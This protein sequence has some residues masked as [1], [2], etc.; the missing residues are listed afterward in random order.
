MGAD[1]I[2]EK[3]CAKISPGRLIGCTVEAPDLRAGAAL[4]VAGLAA[5]GM[6]RV[7]GYAH[8]RRGYEDIAGDLR[9]LGAPVVLREEKQSVPG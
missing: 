3:N 7:T 1:I 6:T 9:Q 2:I 4:A 5:E 8:I